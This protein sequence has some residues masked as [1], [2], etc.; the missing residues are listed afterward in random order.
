M[1][2]LHRLVGRTALTVVLAILAWPAGVLAWGPLGHQTVGAVAQARLTPRAGV[3]LAILLADDRGRDNAPSG[4][5]TLAQ[6]STWAD[7]IRGGA[8]DH[9]AWHY[10][11]MPVCRQLG[12]IPR[13]PDWCPGGECASARIGKL[14][15]VLADAARPLRERNEALKWLV[16]LVGDLHQPLHAADF[17]EGATRVPVELEGWTDKSALSLHGA[18]DVRL[19]SAA[20]HVR[21]GQRPSAATLRALVE[22]AGHLDPAQRRAP[23]AAWLAESNRLARGVAL[24]YPGF[25]CGKVPAAPIVLSRAYQ[26]KAQRVIR[27][28]LALAGARLA[29]LLNGALDPPVAPH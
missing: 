24:D 6:I 21:Q 13:E 2:T 22:R 17:A 28:R 27:D 23:P 8:L 4:R 18:W 20:L 19:V 26:N 29:Y 9:P 5:T 25:A 3:Q 14:A 16:H 11:N 7:E 15:A 12:P 10:D 1:S